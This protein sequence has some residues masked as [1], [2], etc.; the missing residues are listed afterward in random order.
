MDDLYVLLE[1]LVNMR[2]QWYNLGLQLNLG[3]ETLDR[4]RTRFSDTRDQLLEM[5]K[6][7]LTATDNT[8]WKAL[9]D[10]L[11]SRSVNESGTADYLESKYCPMKDMHESKH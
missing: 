9:A 1:E 4:I 7:W 5:L 2:E 6:V 3:P 8:S 10:A 11:K